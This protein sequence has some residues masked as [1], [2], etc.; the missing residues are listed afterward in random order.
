MTDMKNAAYLTINQQTI[1]ELVEKKSRFIAIA[2]P[3]SNEDDAKAALAEI[4]TI[5]KN[6]NHYVYAWSTIAD[7]AMM[8]S[9]DAGEPAGTAGKPV[10][11]TIKNAKLNDIMIIVVRFFGG[12]LLGSGGLLRAYAKAAQMVLDQTTF[13]EKIAANKYSINFAYSSINY[14]NKIL[15]DLKIEVSGNIFAEQ[16]C[17]ICM[18]DKTRKILLEEKILEQNLSDVRI[19]DLGISGYIYL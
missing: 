16:V 11:S 7:R 14:F 6:A 12:I 3:V 17:Y 19:D 2:I 4:K 18:I 10:L 15:T 8:R 5:Y 9:S 13:V 1:I